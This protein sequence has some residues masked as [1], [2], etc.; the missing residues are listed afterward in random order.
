[1]HAVQRN[2]IGVAIVCAGFAA[3]TLL[4]RPTTILGRVVETFDGIPAA[5]GGWRSVEADASS[6]TKLLPNS[7]VFLRDYYNSAGRVATVSIVYSLDI[8]DI[9]DPHYCF[10]S[11]GWAAQN[12]HTVML[13][14]GHPVKVTLMKNGGDRA[15]AVYWYSGPDGYRTDHA[16]RRLDVWRNAALFQTVRPT[17]LVRIFLPVASDEKAALRDALSLANLLDPSIAQMVSRAPT[18]EPARRAIGQ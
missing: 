13:R 3:L 2:A 9:H 8:A 15:V 5:T 12:S 1:M 7:S 16:D 17:A 11:V 14:T 10:E 6:W 18:I 4:V